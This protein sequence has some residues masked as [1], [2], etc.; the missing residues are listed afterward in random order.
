MSQ[1]RSLYARQWHAQDDL[2]LAMS[3]GLAIVR[4]RAYIGFL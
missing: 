1:G 2:I 4:P 3:L